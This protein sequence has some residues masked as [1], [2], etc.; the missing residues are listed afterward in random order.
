M[1]PIVL[2]V[3][4]MGVGITSPPPTPHHDTMTPTTSRRSIAS[5]ALTKHPIQYDIQIRIVRETETKQS[6]QSRN[7]NSGRNGT[8]IDS[9]IP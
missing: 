2:A 3:V 4:W 5:R 6:T 1:V 9:S 8:S 7:G